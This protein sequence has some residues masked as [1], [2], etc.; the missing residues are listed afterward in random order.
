MSEVR[1]DLPFVTPDDNPAWLYHD[2]LVSIDA[3]RGLNNGMPSFWAGNFDA[4]DVKR[5]QRIL[6][7]GAGVG[8]YSA[9]L[10]ELVGLEGHVT[11]V[12]Y[13]LEL[14]ARACDNLSD[15]GNVEVVAGDG[16]THDAGEVDIVVVFA[17]A[18]HPAPLWLERLKPGGQLLLPLTAGR[19]FGFLLLARR[20]GAYHGS[21]IVLP[22]RRD[23]NSY[24][25]RSIGRVG[26][27]PCMGGR[28]DEAAQR[29][30]QAIEK[31]LRE[32]P[33]GQWSPAIPICA[34]H[35]GD[36]RPAVEGRVW[37]AGPGFW[38]ERKAASES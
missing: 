28:D 24:E 15:R 17:G 18:T 3:A 4:L 1:P 25:A 19:W 31:V 6:Q 30:E 23:P 8:Y 20:P 35:R 10:A 22:E 12:E 33:R 9:I 27:F 13:D 38:L 32:A 29:L 16:R 26:I 11:A 34:L 36:P 5:G 14:A 2:V 7:V 21:E 37:Y